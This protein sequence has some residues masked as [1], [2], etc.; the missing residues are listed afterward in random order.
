MT[1]IQVLHLKKYNVEN[2]SRMK[3]LEVRDPRRTN[4]NYLVIFFVGGL[5]D[6]LNGLLEVPGSQDAIQRHAQHLQR[7]K[8]VP[9]YYIHS[10]LEHQFL[11]F[12]LKN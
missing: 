10:E 4:I 7:Y 6:L 2:V 8:R 1:N 9:H 5:L 11:Y 3:I 12:E